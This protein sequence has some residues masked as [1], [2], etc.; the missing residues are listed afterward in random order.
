MYLR[1]KERS[2]RPRSFLPR[3]DDRPTVSER[4]TIVRSFLFCFRKVHWS[5][6][7][8]IFLI[9]REGTTIWGPVPSCSVP[10]SCCVVVLSSRIRY[11]SRRLV[12]LSTILA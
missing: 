2:T 8:R 5:H 4:A 6:L 3:M 1:G 7:P 10:G 12:Q 9:G 11:S